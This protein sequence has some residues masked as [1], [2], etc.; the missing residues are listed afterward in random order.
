[1]V[2]FM[3]DLGLKGSSWDIETPVDLVRLITSLNNLKKHIDEELVEALAASQKLRKGK[4]FG[5]RHKE[6][7][8]STKQ[9]SRRL[10]FEGTSGT[11]LSHAMPASERGA[12]TMLAIKDVEEGVELDPV[13]EPAPPVKKPKQSETP[14]NKDSSEPLSLKCEIVRLGLLCLFSVL[15]PSDPKYSRLH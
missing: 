2:S 5:E 15:C 6:Q 14:G 3:E 12:A 11:G 10:E 1:M 13:P 4:V 9:I 7:R 8:L